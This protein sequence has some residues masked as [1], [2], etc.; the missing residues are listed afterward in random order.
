MI[1]KMDLL[2]CCHRAAV[3]AS[4]ARRQGSAEVMTGRQGPVQ[5]RRGRWSRVAGVVLEE[6]CL[7]QTQTGDEASPARLRARRYGKAVHMLEA[8]GRCSS[9][10]RIRGPWGRG[11]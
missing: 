8:M 7:G 5:E 4:G 3:K 11:I 2:E 6:R 9:R 10:R 1:I